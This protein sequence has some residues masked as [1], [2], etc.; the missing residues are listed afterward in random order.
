MSTWSNTT[1]KNVVAAHVPTI[2]SV[3]RCHNT[4]RGSIIHQTKTAFRTLDAIGTSKKNDD[5]K[6]HSIRTMKTYLHHAIMFVT[7]CRDKHGC[8]NIEDCKPFVK[9]WIERDGL[10]ASTRKMERSALA[11]MYQCKSCDFGEIETGTRTRDSITRSR[12]EAIRDK[13]FSESGRYKDYVDF[14]KSTGLRK[15]EIE[16]LKGN[17]LF[18][19]NGKAYLKVTE[20]TKGG[21]ERVVP[22]I[23]AVERVESVCKASR[24]GKVIETLTGGAKA[25]NGADTHSYRS[26]YAMT[27][28]N[29][30]A[31]PIDEIPLVDR[32]VCRK[33]KRGIVYDKKAMMQ[34]SLALGHTRISVI[35]Q[36]YLR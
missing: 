9:E 30:L 34:V 6:I 1:I 33:D 20:N 7:Y 15:V 36:S 17:A 18:Y 19:E 26:D 32:Y 14:C 10:S 21:R 29:S 22:V 8:R 28:Y 27:L 31:R 4:K 3:R 5:E 11:K 23:N 12:G 25:P 13:H 35:A 2:P 24:Q 16:T